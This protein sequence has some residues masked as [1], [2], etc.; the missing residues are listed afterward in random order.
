M[1]QKRNSRGMG[2]WRRI[3]CLGLWVLI[4]TAGLTA[5][6]GQASSG[7]RSMGSVTEYTPGQIRMVAATERNRYQNIYTSQLWS[8]AADGEGNTFETLLKGQV[9]QFLKELAVVNLL[10]EKNG[11]QLTSQ[12]K[13]AVQSL[14][15]EYYSGLT[16]GDLDYMKV[17]KDEVYD[18]YSKYYLADKTVSQLTNEED[19]E[20]SDAE[21]KV[22]HIQQIET[23][24]EEKAQEVYEMATQEKADFAAVAAKE[25]QN[26]QIEYELEW[27]GD[28]TP[29]EQSAFSLEQ[30]Q[31]S[32]VISYEGKYY[33][34]KCTNAYDKD[35]TAARKIK[36]LEEKKARAFDQIYTPFSQTNPV[37]LKE[38]MWDE[39][40]FSGGEECT[41]DNFFQLYHTS[42]Q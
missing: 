15:D 13:D 36:L 1:N 20:V 21:A 11:I 30:D 22:I 5:C 19:L 32:K 35:A 25:S 24:T 12:E 29:L 16:K 4:G 14:T 40:D 3:L 39:M 23:D 42:R 27:S 34:Q 31:I 7:Q 38:G 9:E 8:V 6:S 37:R 26:S 41:A 10:A 18:L 28:M 2:M 33:I 17:S